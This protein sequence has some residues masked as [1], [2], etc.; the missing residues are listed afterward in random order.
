MSIKESSMT[1]RKLVSVLATGVV[2][3]LASAF[4]HA[5]APTTQ[6]SE[7]WRNDPKHEARRVVA[8]A[9][10]RS[11]QKTGVD[12]ILEL[13]NKK[14]RARLEKD[15]DRKEEQKFQKLAADAQAMWKEKYG[16]NFDAAMN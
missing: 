2:L 13:V 3:S 16:K 9:A 4:T 6:G 10:D 5:A 8:Q 11:L 7:A 15:I 1:R 14:D 12:G